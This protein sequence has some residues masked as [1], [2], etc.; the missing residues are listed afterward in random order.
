MSVSGFFQFQA[1]GNHGF[2]KPET[3]P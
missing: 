2:R 1:S 3:D